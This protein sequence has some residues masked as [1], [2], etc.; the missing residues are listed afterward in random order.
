VNIIYTATLVDGS[1][2]PSFITLNTQ[3]RKFTISSIDPG[4]V[5]NYL[6]NLIG[7]AVNSDGSKVVNEILFW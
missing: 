2:L 3:A 5:N 4:D 7:T 6:I 1:S